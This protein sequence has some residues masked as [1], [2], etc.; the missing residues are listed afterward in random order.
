MFCTRRFDIVTLQ[1]ILKLCT[2]HVC[3]PD[4]LQL[5]CRTTLP[6]LLAL[7]CTS[8]YALKI[9]LAFCCDHVPCCWCAKSLCLIS[10][11]IILLATGREI[12]SAHLH[13]QQQIRSSQI[14]PRALL[15]CIVLPK[16]PICCRVDDTSGRYHVLDVGS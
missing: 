11:I 13:P 4:E 7:R 5:P 1:Q 8:L 9:L 12:V 14:L 10:N 3:L 16:W 15:L 2:L 6:E